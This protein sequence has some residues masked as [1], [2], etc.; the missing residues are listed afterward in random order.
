MLFISKQPYTPQATG[1]DTDNPLIQK[2]WQFIQAWAKNRP[3]S[4]QGGSYVFDLSIYSTLDTMSNSNAAQ[5]TIQPL[6]ELKYLSY[7]LSEE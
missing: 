1:D 4:S 6:L 5:S 3:I 2:I 7:S